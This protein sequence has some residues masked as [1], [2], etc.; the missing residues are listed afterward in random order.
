[1]EDKGIG[2][3]GG[4]GWGVVKGVECDYWVGWKG[5][6]IFKLHH[7]GAML[8]ECQLKPLHPNL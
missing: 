4:G 8:V 3:R 1:M 6:K 5:S 2:E 7:I